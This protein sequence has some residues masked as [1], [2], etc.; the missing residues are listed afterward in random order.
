[1]NKWRDEPCDE[2]LKSTGGHHRDYSEP[3]K[4]SSQI[5]SA[6]S[7][8]HE[9]DIIYRDLKPKN[10]GINANGNVKLFDFGF[11]RLLPHERS[12]DDTFKMT[13]RIG[14]LRYMAPEVALKESYNLKVDVYSW[15]II[16]WEMLSLE[17]PY[18]TIPREQFLTLVCQREERHKLDPVW[19]KSLRDLIGR[20]WGNHIST[21]P[22]MEEVYALVNCVQE[23]MTRKECAEE[24]ETRK[25][26][27]SNSLVFPSSLANEKRDPLAGTVRTAPST[28]ESIARDSGT[29]GDHAYRSMKERGKNGY[30]KPAHYTPTPNAMH[31]K[32]AG[33][34][35]P[36]ASAPPC[37]TSRTATSTRESTTRVSYTVP[38]QTLEDHTYRPMEERGEGVNRNPAHHSPASNA[39]GGRPADAS[40]SNASTWPSPPTFRTAP[41]SRESTTRNSCTVTQRARG[42]HAHRTTDERGDDGYRKS[43]QNTPAPTMLLGGRLADAST[44]NASAWPSR[45]SS[46]VGQSRVGQF[47]RGMRRNPVKDG[48]R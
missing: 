47:L 36:N 41:T 48:K 17:N 22:T 5:A 1:M 25:P 10:I 28:G 9:R 43:A 7:Y 45:G 4:Y 29:V 19:P 34:F 35:M 27:L 13:G 42:D 12:V 14:T 44:P 8:L 2:L 39:M 37:A 15:S 6:I 33:A 11:A 18:Q 31:G 46:H 23:E 20:S 24:A 16:L 40:S 21:R 26:T 38:R 3:L 30:R 32:P